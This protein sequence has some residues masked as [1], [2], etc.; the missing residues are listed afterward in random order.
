VELETSE[1]LDHTELFDNTIWACK[2]DYSISGMEFV[3]PVLYSDRGLEE[4]EK[5]CAAGC[6][7]QIDSSC[8]YHAHFDITNESWE[9]LRSIAYA[10]W[11]T[12]QLWCLFVSD[13]R[14]TNSMCSAPGY[15]G[16]EIANI[17][18]S[19]D[20]DYFVGARDR[21]E[22]V[23]WRAYFVHSTLEVRLHD[24]SLNSEML[25]NWVKCHARF[26]DFVSSCSID[27]IDELFSNS[28]KKQFETLTDIVGEE[29]SA[30]Y[31][32]RAEQFDKQINLTSVE[33]MV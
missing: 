27:E 11:K 12:Y 18:S 25:C 3:S 4:I 17:N 1:C 14:C 21:F 16:V 10:Y 7:W 33:S 32:G 26:I 31:A 15:N 6:G 24:A 8:G 20:W 23:N 9:S 22:F 19:E 28:F 13:Y 5:L 2:T 30:Y 29:L